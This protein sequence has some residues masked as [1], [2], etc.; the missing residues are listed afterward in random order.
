V[1]AQ[2][3]FSMASVEQFL[4][5]TLHFYV[6]C[7]FSVGCISTVRHAANIKG[8]TGLA[9]C[10]HRLN[11]TD[12]LTSHTQNYLGCKFKVEIVCCSFIYVLC[13]SSSTWVKGTVV[14]V[15]NLLS[16]TS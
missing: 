8:K 14:P 3:I 13:V 6:M 10:G 1:D 9:I 16:I 5:P 2:E 11:N 12:S 7:Q 4:A 15:L